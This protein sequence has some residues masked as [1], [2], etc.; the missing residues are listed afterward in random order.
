MA[1]KAH[2]QND[3]Q[4]QPWNNKAGPKKEPVMPVREIQQGMQGRGHDQV[5]LDSTE[6]GHER[7]RGDNRKQGREGQL[8]EVDIEPRDVRRQQFNASLRRVG[9]A[10]WSD[11]KTKPVGTAPECLVPKLQR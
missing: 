5:P 1:S 10:P 6:G 4:R 11:V 9:I 3:E 7:E 8:E 2:T